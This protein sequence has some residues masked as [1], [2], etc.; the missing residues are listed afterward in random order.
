MG[1]SESATSAPAAAKAGERGP[2]E[3]EI[4]L[5]HT[6]RDRRNL[7]LALTH[8]SLAY[9]QATGRGDSESSDAAG[10]HEADQDNEQLEFLG[11]AV[12]GLIVAESLFRSFPDLNEGDLTRLRAQ[13]VSRR[14]LGQ[15]GARLSLGSFLRLGR[16]EE[17]SGG[18]Q[19]AV[20]LAN[21]MEAVIAALYLDGG[22]AAAVAFVE[23][24]IVKPYV[25]ELRAEL[26]AGDAMGDHKSAL[27]EWLQAH[28]AGSP[29]YTVK[30]ESGPDHRKRFLVEVEVMSEAGESIFA[31]GNGSTK[32]K[33]EQE[34]ARKAYQSVRR[35][36]PPS[37]EPEAEAIEPVAE[38]ARTVRKSAGKAK[39]S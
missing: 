16:G 4:V 31:L 32:K 7:E 2:T 24:S 20:L 5:G 13:L 6:F 35:A 38:A 22:L 10:E 23:G 33:A 29:H 28:K 17:R 15:V 19:K 30:G 25:E 18:R 37:V 1:A 3:L 14:H 39:A 34:A 12:L 8:S 26:D 27:Q 9:E 11:D 36:S 21:A